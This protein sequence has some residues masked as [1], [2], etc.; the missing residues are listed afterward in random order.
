M[1]ITYT[2]EVYGYLWSGGAAVYSYNIGAPLISEAEAKAAAGDFESLI[3]YRVVRCT[4]TY[5]KMRGGLLRR[6]DVWKTL[7]GFRSGKMTPR[8]FYRLANGF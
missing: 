3:D 1:S 2:L 4:T 8:R 5:E 6:C 7:R